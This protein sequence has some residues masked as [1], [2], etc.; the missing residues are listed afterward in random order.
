MSAKAFLNNVASGS[1]TATLEGT[2]GPPGA[3]V[4]P[5]RLNGASVPLEAGNHRTGGRCR[6]KPAASPAE[7]PQRPREAPW[8]SGSGR[9]ARAGRW[10]EGGRGA[11]LT[12]WG[13]PQLAQTPSVCTTSRL[14]APGEATCARKD[15][16]WAERATG[17]RVQGRRE[18]GTTYS[19]CCCHT[20]MCV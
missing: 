19:L 18:M 10:A 9:H 4:Q 8:L 6:A 15:A 17:S 14:T 12:Q 7:L 16:F 13:Q 11:G 1:H 3:Q 2:E 20:F 5:R